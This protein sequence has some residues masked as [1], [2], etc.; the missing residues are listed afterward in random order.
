MKLSGVRAGVAVASCISLF[1]C[2]TALTAPS[3]IADTVTPYRFYNALYGQVT[4]SPGGFIN[5]A[6]FGAPQYATSCDLIAG[7]QEFDGAYTDQAQL[8]Q[9]GANSHTTFPVDPITK[10]GVGTIGP[11]PNGTYTL[12]FGC[13][14]NMLMNPDFVVDGPIYDTPLVKVRLDG[15]TSVTPLPTP[16][17]QPQ[18]ERQP[19]KPEQDCADARS[20]LLNSVPPGAEVGISLLLK[21][22]EGLPGWV[23]STLFIAACISEAIDTPSPDG[24]A[25]NLIENLNSPQFFNALC[26]TAEAFVDPFNLGWSKDVYCGAKVG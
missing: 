15:G 19:T 26:R 6:V 18:Q 24:G 11:L 12:I 22:L 2:V 8:A 14:T 16:P 5:V 13:G 23:S 7:G 25:P 9:I 21:R 3:A 10:S 20:E 17:P 4:T 1:V